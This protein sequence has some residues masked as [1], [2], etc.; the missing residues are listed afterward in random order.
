MQPPSSSSAGPPTAEPSTP[1]A[2]PTPTPPPDYAKIAG[3]VKDGVLKVIATGCGNDGTRVGSAFLVDDDTAVAS[4]ASLAGAQTV[5]VFNGSESVPAEV[6]SADTEHGVVVLKLDRSID[7]H[8]FDLDGSAP[9]AKDPVGLLGIKTTGS[10][11]GL[12]TTK[13]TATS[14]TSKVGHDTVSGLASTG[15]NADDGWAGGPTLAEDGQANGMI[16]AGPG[17][18]TAM[19]VPGSAIKAAAKSKDP[20]PSATCND[21]KGPDV[22]VIGGK[23]TKAVEAVLQDYFGGINSGDYRKAYEQLGPHSNSGD[24]SSYVSGWRSAYDYNIN[25]HSVSGSGD[26]SRA[27]ISF[28]A[29]TLPGQG[30]KGHSDATCARWDMT[31]TFISSGGRLLIDRVEASPSL[32]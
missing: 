16:F 23:P 24:F 31:Y 10:A 2:S 17:S 27:K 25:V 3:K 14:K 9:K 4:Y 21:P 15:L 22:T 18:S 20:L 1:K 29:I 13:I 19:I 6:K 32:C 5:V 26:G 7:G 12:E 30:P 8:V 11:P 28:N